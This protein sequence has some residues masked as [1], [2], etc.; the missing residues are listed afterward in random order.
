M[1]AFIIG[2]AAMVVISVGTMF[3]MD[4]AFDFSSA[5]VYQSDSGSV[6]LH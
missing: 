5:A 3:V 1:K 2:V 6:R 4:E